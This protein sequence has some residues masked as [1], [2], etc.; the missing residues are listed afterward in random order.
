M[1]ATVDP[2]VAARFLAEDDESVV[3]RI[4]VPAGTKGIELSGSSYESELLLQRGLRMRV[5]SDSGPGTAPR[6]IDVEV[7]K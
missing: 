3:M 4:V 6:R 2:K 7:I 1:S 5:A